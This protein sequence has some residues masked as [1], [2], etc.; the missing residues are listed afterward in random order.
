MP[1]HVPIN[2]LK[3]YRERSG[4]QQKSQ[5]NKEGPEGSSHNVSA[6]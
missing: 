5:H 3:I 6:D 1:P 4:K 2:S